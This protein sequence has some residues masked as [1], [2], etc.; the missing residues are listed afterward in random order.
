MCRDRIQ[1]LALASSLDSPIH[2]QVIL[3]VKGGAPIFI[4]FGFPKNPR[5]PWAI[6]PLAGTGEASLRV[7]PNLKKPH[8]LALNGTNRPL[9]FIC[10][11]CGADCLGMFPPPLTPCPMTE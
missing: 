10:R 5:R 2:P 11:Q 1:G 6:V 9:A 4:S 7:T 3:Q 8:R